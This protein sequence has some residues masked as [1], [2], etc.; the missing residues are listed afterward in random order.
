[1]IHIAAFLFMILFITAFHQGAEAGTSATH[2]S[3]LEADLPPLIHAKEFYG[4]RYKTWGYQLSPDGERLAWMERVKGRPTLRVRVLKSG[5]TVTINHPTRVITFYWARDSRHLLSSTIVWPR[6]NIHPLLSDTDSP[7][8]RPRDLLPFEGVNIRSIEIPLTKPDSVF[9]EA[10]LR[11]RRTPDLYEINLKSG[12]HKLRATNPG[13]TLRW[14]VNDEGGVVGRLQRDADGG[15]SVQ[16]AAGTTTWATM[17]VGKVADSLEI[18]RYVSDE[19]SRVYMITN[20]ER[21]KRALV[22]LDLSTGAQE[23]VFQRPDVDVSS[24]FMHVVA[25]E[26]LVVLYHDDLPRYHYFDRKL[27]EDVEK[28]LGPGPILYTISSG[29]KDRMR[30]TIQT[31]TDRL[32]RSTYLIDRRSGAKTLLVAHPLEGYK[33]ILSPTRPMRIRARDGL[34]ISGYLT[35][36]KGTAGKRLPM[37]LKV[38]GGPWQRDYWGFDSDA[39]FLAN[40]GYAVLEVNFR[41]SGGF[42]KSFMEK[43]IRELGRKMQNDLIDAVDWAI[44]EGYADPEKVAIYGHS[45]GGY[46]TLVGLTKTPRKFAAGVSV[47]G[48][49]DLASLVSTYS[50]Y[51]GWP[52]V[53]WTRFAGDPED[54][55]A[56]RELTERSP[57]T[58]AHRVERP[59]LIVHGAEDKRVS[60]DHSDRFV[61]KLREK[62]IPVEY[63]VFPDERH[64]IRESKNLVEL[65][66]RLETFLAAHLGGRAGLTN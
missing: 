27:Q 33:E 9:V 2:P 43:G 10:D 60:K 56:R 29:S 65:A 47:V 52:R 20:G 46:A 22:K 1:M 35:I 13:N 40:R 53:M 36:P 26:P 5:H 50:R 54:S 7:Q 19:R 4:R 66:R 16:A 3:L 15:W 61:E 58:Y 38:H 39:Q 24:V 37:V 21:D 55:D 8:K 45:Y 41:G 17:L 25:H 28:I 12:V 62:D 11:K 32:G 30:L 18:G 44:A 63:L 64:V 14:I 51:G 31:E 23:L 34:S 49:S 42:G 59:L 48:P 57:I 6:L